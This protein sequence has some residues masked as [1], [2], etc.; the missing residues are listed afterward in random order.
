MPVTTA[1]M[2]GH[3]QTLAGTLSHL[4]TLP[5][6]D[7]LSQDDRPAILSARGEQMISHRVLHEF[8][9]N[10]ALPVNSTQH[11][12]VI[13][14]A[15]PNGP[16]LA[17]ACIAVSTYYTAAPIDPTTGPDE[18]QADVVQSGARCILT[19]ESDYQRLLLAESWTQNVG[20]Q[21]IMVEW[22]ENSIRLRDAK[23]R[24]L[25]TESLTQP[26][27]NHADDIAIVLSTNGPWGKEVIPLTTH[28]ILV[29][30]V[31]TMGTWGLGPTDVGINMMALH[32][33]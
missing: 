11:K 14:I 24:R 18:F 1:K 5:A 25:S 12:P 2:D 16:L 28:T 20:V 30:A 33:M 13:A 19:T 23:G 26:E 15:L 4:Y 3:H 6:T 31:S 21:A 22:T 7:L 17:A 10:F 27:P 9:D 8:V 29:E 32:Q